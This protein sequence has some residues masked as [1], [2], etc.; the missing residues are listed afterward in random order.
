MTSI[1]RTGSLFVVLALAACSTSTTVGPD[2]S[3]G[4]AGDGGL[5]IT[6]DAG[7]DVGPVDFGTDAGSSIGHPCTSDAD[8][9]GAMCDTMITGYCIS[10][11]SGGGTCPAN[12]VCVNVGFGGMAYCLPTCDPTAT[13][14]QCGMGYGC[15]MTM[16]GNVCLPGCTDDTDCAA[17][18]MCDPTAGGNGAGACFTPGSHV[19]DAC[20]MD[21]MCPSA[22]VC[23]DEENYGEPGGACVTQGCDAGS[24]AGCPGDAVCRPQRFGGGLCFDGCTVD[25]DC[26]TA[27]RCLADA[28][29]PTRHYCAPGC[30]S[31]AQCTFAGNVC[32]PTTGACAPP[33]TTSDIGGNCGSRMATVAC[34]GGSCFSENT[35]GF[36]YSYCSYLG[37]T[38]GGTECGTGN[39]CATALRT[40]TH[41]CLDGC[42][43]TTDC[44][45]GYACLPSDR[46]DSASPLACQPACT[47]DSQCQMRMTGMNHCNTGTGLCTQPFTAA[48]EGRPC[49]GP[50]DCVGG[51]C[52]TEAAA[53][54]PMGECVAVGCRVSGTGT[55]G[56]TCPTTA[57]CV[58]D[59]IGDPEIG[60]CQV[61]CMVGATGGCR[62]GY[63]CVA[64]GG[65]GT[66]GTCQPACAAADCTSPLTCNTTTGLCGS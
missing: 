62:A 43:T 3:T 13:P 20:T 57:T 41:F 45:A 61:S 23:L 18:T 58:D 55:T 4:D 14:R 15:G 28:T 34:D 65:T 54:Y 2:G 32:N 51:Y 16:E 33:L 36:P 35:T 21:T 19:G 56:I 64:I 59:G 8:C 25:T 31:S 6:F 49:A 22:G 37:C 24:G 46:A 44:R 63:A 17:G 10:D 53:G 39:V 38:P 60:E 48:N 26:R 7:P 66:A 27:Y 50:T 5:I 40:G 12:A 1:L 11:C 29:Y 52:Y 47:A 42:T 30:T 9:P